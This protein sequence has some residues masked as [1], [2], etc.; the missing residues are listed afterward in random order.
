MVTPA[1]LSIAGPWRE[2]PELKQDI[3][4]DTMLETIGRSKHASASG[5]MRL[6]MI[7][8]AF[9]VDVVAAAHVKDKL[10]AWAGGLTQLTVG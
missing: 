10:K 5:S 2:I 3:A 4:V 6:R 9:G 8:P 1:F 7:D